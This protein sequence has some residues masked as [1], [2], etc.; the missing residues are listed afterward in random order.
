MFP[1]RPCEGPDPGRRSGIPC[2]DYH[3][4][5]CLA[6]CVGYMSEE[7]YRELIDGMI[8]FLEGRSG[9]IERELPAR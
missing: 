5:R 1:Y 3:I 7:G 6:P 4:G 9:P 2:L 8:E